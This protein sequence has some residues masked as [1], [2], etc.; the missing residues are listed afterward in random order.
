M[1]KLYINKLFQLDFFL[2]VLKINYP[3]MYPAHSEFKKKNKENKF[4]I[5]K[6]NDIFF[7]V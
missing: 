6:L 4:A 2:L 3:Q 5:A 7:K 1:Q